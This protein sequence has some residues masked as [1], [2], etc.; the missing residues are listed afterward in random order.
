M[1]RVETWRAGNFVPIRS[2]RVRYR[3]RRDSLIDQKRRFWGGNF[4][5]CWK[6]FFGHKFEK[7]RIVFL[8]ICT[9]ITSGKFQPQ[10]PVSCG[11][12]SGAQHCVYTRGV[13]SGPGLQIAAGISRATTSTIPATRKLPGSRSRHHK[14]TRD[15]IMIPA[16]FPGQ[17]TLWCLHTAHHRMDLMGCALVRASC[18]A[19]SWPEQEQWSPA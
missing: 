3:W 17:R 8:Y 12:M 13:V 15:R 9:R 19:S 11:L 6:G 18:G 4:W 5:I 10:L 1:A 14:F 7:L 16:V 2:Q